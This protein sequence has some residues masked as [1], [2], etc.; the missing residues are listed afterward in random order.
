M[1]RDVQT[2][3]VKKTDCRVSI[4]AEE[5]PSVC[6]KVEEEKLVNNTILCFSYDVHFDRSIQ[7]VRFECN[8]F[9]RSGVLCRHGVAVFHLYKVF[10]VPTCYVLPR[11]SKNI[12]CKHTYVKDSHDISRSDESHTAFREL[13]AH[14]YIVAQE[15]VNEDDKIVLCIL[16]WK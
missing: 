2:E 8:L 9:E 14:F 7:E 10:K 11:W 15:F 3:F 16:L 1:F 4:V 13:C 5:W 12:K 6:M